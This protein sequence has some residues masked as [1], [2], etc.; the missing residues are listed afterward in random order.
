MMALSLAFVE[1]F[2]LSSVTDVASMPAPDTL[3]F[4]ITV[5][6]PGSSKVTLGSAPGKTSEHVQERGD[7]DDKELS[8]SEG[9]G[10]QDDNNTCSDECVYEFVAAT[11]ADRDRWVSFLKRHIKS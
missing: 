5:V 1:S 6:N 11:E 8:N 10:G 3:V 4:R 7:K 9:G 2:A